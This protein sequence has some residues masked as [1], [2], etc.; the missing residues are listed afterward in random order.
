M[1]ALANTRR[2]RMTEKEFIKNALVAAQNDFYEQAT[3]AMNILK[4]KVSNLQRATSDG[5]RYE[6]NDFYDELNDGLIFVCN[7][8]GDET[9]Q[10]FNDLVKSVTD[11][12]N[13]FVGKYLP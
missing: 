10:K 12:I 3:S 4:F 6:C 5:F 13:A 1:I 7:V 8:L 2:I 9:T 11:A